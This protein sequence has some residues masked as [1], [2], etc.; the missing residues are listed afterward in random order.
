M[1]ESYMTAIL[2][3]IEQWLNEWLFKEHFFAL[4]EGCNSFIISTNST[5]S[6]TLYSWSDATKIMPV[7][8]QSV[9]I[10]IRKWSCLKGSITF[11]LL[12]NG[13]KGLPVTHT[14]HSVMHPY[15]SLFQRQEHLV[16]APRWAAV[17]FCGG[18]VLKIMMWYS[19]DF[20][21]VYKCACSLQRP[22]DIWNPQATAVHL[23][24]NFSL[25]TLFYRQCIS[26]KYYWLGGNGHMWQK[27]MLC[28]LCFQIHC[29]NQYTGILLTPLL[30]SLS[31][32]I[33]V[34]LY[35]RSCCKIKGKDHILSPSVT[36]HIFMPFN[37]FM[38]K[39]KTFLTLLAIF[40]RFPSST[41]I[42]RK[43]LWWR[44]R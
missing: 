15:N 33:A 28:H 9:W 21:L 37:L 24:P 42:R 20:C 14:S 6:H 38:G 5:V 39:Y 12:S 13:H 41:V 7:Q 18:Y 22:L 10:C 17:R 32:A 19:G 3:P 31:I 35:K 25:F 43:L 23:K 29:Q 36:S 27:Y 44:P 4:V 1:S 8:F 40:Y 16:E 34:T 11:F 26:W 2:K 30:N